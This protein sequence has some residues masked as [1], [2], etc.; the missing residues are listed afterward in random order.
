MG[1][2]CRLKL[3]FLL[4]LSLTWNLHA[5]INFIQ[6]KIIN[7]SSGNLEFDLN[8]DSTVDLTMTQNGLLGIGLSNPTSTL[9][10][11]GSLGF[12][13][14]STSSN[15]TLSGNSLVLGDSSL[16]NLTLT[17]PSASTV[18][19]RLYQIKK[20]TAS[21]NLIVEAGASGNLDGSAN[22]VLGTATVG[23]PYLNV[24]S[25]GSTWLISSTSG[26]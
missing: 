18:P 24:F 12:S 9:Q 10:I 21:N 25:N 4:A 23:F 11:S 15:I 5:T 2:L 1:N 6:G 26:N 16:G 17:L 13:T 22:L 8:N 3:S 20:V 14:Q 19:G 7:H